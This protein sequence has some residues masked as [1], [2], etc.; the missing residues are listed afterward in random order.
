[1]FVMVMIA[2]LWSFNPIDMFIIYIGQTNGTGCPVMIAIN[3]DQ[4][5]EVY[6]LTIVYSNP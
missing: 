4:E 1:M 2:Y 5:F 3:V 6:Y